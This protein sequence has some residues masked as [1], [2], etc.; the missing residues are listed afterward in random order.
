V[1]SVD[2][3]AGVVVEL[4]CSNHY[5]GMPDCFPD[6]VIES[7]FAE[8]VFRNAVTAVNDGCERRGRGCLFTSSSVEGRVLP[9]PNRPVRF[10]RWQSVDRSTCPRT[11]QT[12]TPSRIARNTR[13]VR[14]PPRVRK[15]GCACS[16][17]TGSFRG[18]H[19]RILYLPARR[20]A[21]NGHSSVMDR[22][23]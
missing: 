16:G 14:Y 23:N 11:L 8:A 17:G 5:G 19:S 9:S 1:A 4:P 21:A 22:L 13:R 18:D 10:E 3:N 2:G 15:K 20:S 7:G 6:D 12:P